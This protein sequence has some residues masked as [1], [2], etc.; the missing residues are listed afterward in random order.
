[1][2]NENKI[3][4]RTYS[5]LMCEE[6]IITGVEKHAIINNLGVLLERQIYISFSH[7]N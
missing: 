6:H 5:F 1:M 3:N 2:C 4:G 7:S